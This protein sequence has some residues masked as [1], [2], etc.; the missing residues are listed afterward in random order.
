[1]VKISKN[2]ITGLLTPNESTNAVPFGLFQDLSGRVGSIETF[3]G[4]TGCTGYTGWTG[5][6]GMTGE[7]GATGY[8]FEQDSSG[9]FITK[10]HLYPKYSCRINDADNDPSGIDL[11]SD[12][13]LNQQRVNSLQEDRWYRGL[14]V[15]EIYTS[16]NSL[17]IVGS[18]NYK[19]HVE[20]ETDGSVKTTTTDP[21][22]N[23][24]VKFSINT[25]QDGTIDSSKLPFT[26]LRFRGTLTPNGTDILTSRESGAI[27]GDYYI[28]QDDGIIPYPEW[29][30]DASGVS[31]G[32]IAIFTDVGVN[33]F[34]K[35]RFNIPTGYIKTQQLY[36]NIF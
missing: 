11:G 8:G 10:S 22:N 20:Y 34:V 1:M 31:S 4:P 19:H 32:D 13:S 16:A 7:T 5:L 36:V 35:V 6:Q 9:H 23:T 28:I 21:N 12:A 29:G 26:G 3:T 24:T 14:F 18:D 2:Q 15:R 30:N 33:E 25:T 27:A 17:H